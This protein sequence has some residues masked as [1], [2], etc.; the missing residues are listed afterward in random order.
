MLAGLVDKSLV[1]IGDDAVESRYGLLE[2][3]RHYAA[4]RLSTSNDEM[5]GALSRHLDWCLVLAEEGQVQL[6]GADQGSWLA[7]LEREHDNLRAALTWARDRTDERGLRVAAALWRFWYMQG[8]LAEGRNWLESLLAGNASAQASTRATALNGAGNLA[9]LQGEYV[10]AATFYEES[11]SL[12]RELGDKRGVAASLT[13]LGVV[14]DKYGDHDR[15]TALY[16]EALALNRE[17]DDKLGM[18]KV[19]GNLGSVFGHQADYEREAALYTEALTLFRQFGDTQSIAVALDNLGL[20]ALRLGELARAA[21]LYEESLALF[22]ALGDRDG[23]AGTL[24]SLG[25]VAARQRAHGRAAALIRES[26]QVSQEL[27]A[28]EQIAEALEAMTVVAS[29]MGQSQR[30]ARLAGATDVL[31]ASL[32]VPMRP[33]LQAGYHRTVRAMYEALG[34]TYDAAWSGGR[35]LSVEQAVDL[36]LATMPRRMDMSTDP[37][38]LS[39]ACSWIADEAPALLTLRP[40]P[41]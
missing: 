16:E 35:T 7:R 12:R 22:R 39:P 23:I 13:N 33:D 8:Y 40:N 21:S 14:A 36:A 5:A 18:A 15:A 24:T 32:G 25:I 1:G 31:R 26:L 27:G 28:R 29:E 19:L 17:L 30:A 34:R 37:V 38:F 2:T 4:E 6:T 20:V 9:V 3:V 11:L 10:Q 41:S